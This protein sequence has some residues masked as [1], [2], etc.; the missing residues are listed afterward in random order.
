MG[1]KGSIYKALEKFQSP[2][3]SKRNGNDPKSR[4]RQRRREVHVDY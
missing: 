2:A 3:A 4:E 1:G